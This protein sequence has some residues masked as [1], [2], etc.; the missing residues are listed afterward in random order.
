MLKKLKNF[1]DT[2]TNTGNK[3]NENLELLCGLMI[4]AANIDGMIEQSEIDKIY[5]ILIDVFKENHEEAKI[6][7]KKAINNRDKLLRTHIKNEAKKHGMIKANYSKHII[8]W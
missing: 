6:Y 8:K 2:E 5:S 3:G 1:F 7:I 4:E